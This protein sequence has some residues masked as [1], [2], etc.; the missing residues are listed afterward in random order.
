MKAKSTDTVEQ[1]RAQILKSEGIQPE[2]QIQIYGG[3]SLE[4]GST[5]ADYDIGEGITLT[6]TRKP[7][8][9][10]REPCA[11]WRILRC[12]ATLNHASVTVIAA[13]RHAVL[14]NAAKTKHIERIA[15]VLAASASIMPAGSSR[16]SNLC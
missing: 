16:I 14:T 4:E 12:V 3:K 7:S 13:A 1:V 6:L 8:G 9:V 15:R 5:L 10:K 2:A 11:D